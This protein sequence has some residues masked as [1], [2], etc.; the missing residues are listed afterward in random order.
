VDSASGLAPNVITVPLAYAIFLS[1]VVVSVTV[2]FSKGRGA[3]VV[4]AETFQLM[5]TSLGL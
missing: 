3:A 2:T 1:P 4:G 5:K